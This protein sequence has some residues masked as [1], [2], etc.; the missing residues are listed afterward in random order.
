MS[1]LEK[2][3]S[4]H[5]LTSRIVSAYPVSF[6]MKDILAGFEN[7][8]I[9]PFS[10]NAVFDEG[11]KAASVVCGGFNESCVLTLHSVGG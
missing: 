11:F 4:I 9:C 10:R 8:G 5:D 3:I 2:K 1:I 6:T 7:S